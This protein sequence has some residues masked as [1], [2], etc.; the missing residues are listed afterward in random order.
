MR[1]SQLWRVNLVNR[2]MCIVAKRK[3]EVYANVTE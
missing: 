1:K 2:K 3:F